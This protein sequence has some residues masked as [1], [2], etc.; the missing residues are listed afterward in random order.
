LY[1]ATLAITYLEQQDNCMIIT[2]IRLKSNQID[3]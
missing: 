2:P 1:A 3:V